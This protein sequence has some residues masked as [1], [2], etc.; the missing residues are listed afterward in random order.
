MT[1]FL[2]LRCLYFEQAR[3]LLALLSLLGLLG[4]EQQVCGVEDKGPML[5]SSKKIKT[6]AH[7]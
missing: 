3:G 1:V 4:R 7:R 2:D 6:G 5:D